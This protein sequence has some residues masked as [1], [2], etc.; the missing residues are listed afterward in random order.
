MNQPAQAHTMKTVRFAHKSALVRDLF[1]KGIQLSTHLKTNPI[2]NVDFED[3]TSEASVL[4]RNY[5]VPSLL[6]RQLVLH[7]NLSPFYLI[8]PSSQVKWHNKKSSADL[9]GYIRIPCLGIDRP[10]IFGANVRDIS[11]VRANADTIFVDLLVDPDYR[12]S[13][14]KPKNGPCISRHDDKRLWRATEGRA[15]K[16]DMWVG[17]RKGRLL[18]PKD[19]RMSPDRAAA[20]PL[21]RFK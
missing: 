21:L 9:D 3:P 12:V 10:W 13:I 17:Q 19:P 15:R 20:A 8:V 7:P 11:G 6:A 2:L 4:S 5:G 16:R 1:K 18:R 14:S